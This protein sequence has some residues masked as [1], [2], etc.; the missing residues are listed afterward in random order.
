MDWLFYLAG[1]VAA[2]AAGIFAI[3]F[4]IRLL[5][6]DRLRI[7][8]VYCWLIGVIVILITL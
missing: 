7:F 8:A 5:V 6:R 3:K 1:I 4:F 2:A